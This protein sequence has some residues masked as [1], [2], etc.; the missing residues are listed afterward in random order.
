MIGIR[1]WKEIGLFKCFRV[2]IKVRSGKDFSGDF[3]GGDIV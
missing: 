2:E 1:R 3:I